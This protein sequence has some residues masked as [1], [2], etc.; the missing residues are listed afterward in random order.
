MHKLNSQVFLKQI[1]NTTKKSYFNLSIRN[2][3]D[4]YLHFIGK[5]LNERNEEKTIYYKEFL[6]LRKKVMLKNHLHLVIC[7]KVSNFAIRK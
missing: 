6:I 5:F 1:K 2:N 4:L 7:E 3:D